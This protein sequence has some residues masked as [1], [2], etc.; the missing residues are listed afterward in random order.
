MT[1]SDYIR[2]RIQPLIRMVKPFVHPEEAEMVS[3]KVEIWALRL[4]ADIEHLGA[5][6]LDGIS[7]NDI[8]YLDKDL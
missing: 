4:I 2:M 5:I 3:I 6:D 8:P 1:K 7:P